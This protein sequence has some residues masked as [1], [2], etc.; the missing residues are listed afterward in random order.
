V[1]RRL[2]EAGFRVRVLVRANSPARAEGP[3]EVLGDID[4]IGSLRRAI[5]GC[6][7]VHISLRG[8]PR[9]ADYERVEHRG[10]ARVAE[11]AAESGC[12]RLSYVSHMLAAPDL[13]STSLRAKWSAE[14][15]IAASGVPY[16][17]F[18]PTYFMDTLPRHIRGRTATV[19]GHQ[20]H[21]FH[22]LAAEDFA[23]MVS[24]A[25]STDRAVNQTLTVYGPEAYT[26]PAALRIYCDLCAPGVTLA[27]RPLWL[28]AALD[29]PPWQ[30]GGHHSAHA[31]SPRT[32]RAGR[33]K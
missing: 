28:M 16:T 5:T 7:A 13:R 4:D 15:A 3:E 27:R 12:V 19:L 2:L 31:C 25:L 6:D 11:V 24:R 29:R 32:R 18:H 17:I 33:P 30:P 1:V 23:A 9:D 20:R 10:T 21:R 22:M 14:H 8:G 26:I